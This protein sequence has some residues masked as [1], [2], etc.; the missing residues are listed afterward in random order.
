MDYFSQRRGYGSSLCS[1]LGQTSSLSPTEF[2]GQSY[3]ENIVG[4]LTSIDNNFLTQRRAQNTVDSPL[5]QQSSPAEIQG[6]SY[7][8][9]I[10]GSLTSVN[11]GLS[12]QRRAQ[13]SS[14]ISPLSVNPSPTEFQGQS[15]Y[16]DILGPIYYFIPT[17]ITAISTPVPTM[18]ATKFLTPLS[19]QV[20]NQN[21]DPLADSRI[22]FIP[23]SSGPS[24]ILNNP[25]P[26]NEHTNQHGQVSVDA[27]ANHIKGSYTIESICY[28]VLPPPTDEYTTIHWVF[29]IPP[30]IDNTGNGGLLDLVAYN[31]GYIN[32]SAGVYGNSIEIPAKQNGLIT[33]PTNIGMVNTGFTISFWFKPVGLNFNNNSNHIVTINLDPL[34]WNTP[35]YLSFVSGANDG[36]LILGGQLGGAPSF[37]ISQKLQL[38]KWHFITIVQAKPTNPSPGYTAGYLY[39]GVFSETGICSVTKS[40]TQVYIPYNIIGVPNWIFGPYQGINY[41]SDTNSYIFDDIRV[42][43]IDR[44]YDYLYNEYLYGLNSINNI[45]SNITPLLPPAYFNLTNL[46]G[47]PITIIIVS[48]NNQHVICNDVFDNPLIIQVLDGYGNSVS[49]VPISFILPPDGA[50]AILGPFSPSSGHTDSNG[51]LSI[52]A[53]A[54]QNGGSYQVGVTGTGLTPAY[55]S[56]TNISRSIGPTP[57]EGPKIISPSK[58]LI[59]IPSVIVDT[60]TIVKK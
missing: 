50:S 41:Y 11:N 3:Y 44:I 38:N 39:V 15:Y 4:S 2:Q 24:A 37:Y 9:N 58:P 1:I 49:D 54:N 12:I 8:E 57:I 28:T 32:Y 60:N 20:N 40:P 25:V 55:F 16:E 19:V 52:I 59:M 10:V 42:E 31:N 45:S 51:Y 47:I 5:A 23:P 29:G 17:T 43:S 56:L 7:Y 22:T 48:G 35:F 30:P 27:T 18:V 14:L 13:N 26:L 46:S 34:S 36:S 6:Q 21:G 53:T 33:A